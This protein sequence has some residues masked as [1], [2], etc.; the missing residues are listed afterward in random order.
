MNKEPYGDSSQG[1]L[2]AVRDRDHAQIKR[3]HMELRAA[4]VEG[5]GMERVL[6]TSEELITATLLHFESEER[7]MAEASVATLGLH[8]ELHA[9]MIETLEDIGKDLEQRKICGA[10][11]L[12]KFFDERLSRHLTVEDAE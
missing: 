8:S 9:G 10:M 12:M 3:I 1:K 2:Q 5:K 7:A 6:R 11:E 4:I